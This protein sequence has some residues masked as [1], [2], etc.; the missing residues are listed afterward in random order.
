MGVQRLFDAGEEGVAVDMDDGMGE[1][2][3][4]AAQRRNGGGYFRR[5]GQ[6]PAGATPKIA[7]GDQPIIKRERSE[8]R[9]V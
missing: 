1:P 9:L 7:E 4:N 2:G 8:L 3:L 6:P 5:E